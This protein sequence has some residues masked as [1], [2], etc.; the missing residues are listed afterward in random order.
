MILPPT[1][2]AGALAA[3]MAEVDAEKAASL[4]RVGQKVER[5]LA[6]LQ[7]APSEDRPARLAEARD[8]V[9]GL[10]VQRE[11]MGQ[12]DHR[13]V[14]AHYGIPPEVLRQLGRR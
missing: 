14:I 1:T 5:A 6:A 9:W 13:A 7:A 12:L 11:V 10:F 2:R 8:A 4:G 3:V